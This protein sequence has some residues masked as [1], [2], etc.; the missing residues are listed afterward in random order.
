[1]PETWQEKVRWSSHLWG[2]KEGNLSLTGEKLV[3][4]SDDG[5]VFSLSPSEWPKIVWP[6][7]GFG[8]NMTILANNR[9]YYV[10]FFARGS[11]LMEWRDA[12]HRGVEWEARLRPGYAPSKAAALLV[13]GFV[14]IMKILWVLMMLLG[15]LILLVDEQAAW[16][17]RIFASLLMLYAVGSGLMWLKPSWFGE[18]RGSTAF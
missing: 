11:S 8:A 17:D 5:E 10:T 12:I 14:D 18:K 16:Y 6:R 3:L 7:Y 2:T 1:M 13:R 4:S 9:R 15:A